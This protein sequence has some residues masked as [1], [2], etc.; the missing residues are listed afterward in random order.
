MRNLAMAIQQFDSA[1]QVP[2][3]AAVVGMIRPINQRRIPATWAGKG[4]FT[5]N[6]IHEIMPYIERQDM[7]DRIELLLSNPHRTSSL[8]TVQQVS[9]RLNLLFA[10]VTNSTTT[11]PRTSR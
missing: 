5:L 8:E 7:R 4:D 11:N 3:V 1:E 6:W 10:P 2:G 9:G